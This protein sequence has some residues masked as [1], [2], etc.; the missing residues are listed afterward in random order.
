MLWQTAAAM[1]STE[2]TSVLPSTMAPRAS[3]SK[4]PVIVAGIVALAAV[5]AT[6]AMYLRQNETAASLQESRARVSEIEGQLKRARTELAAVQQDLAA[7]SAELQ[8]LQEAPL[9]VDVTFRVGRPGTGFIAQF[10]NRSAEPLLVIV[11]V[12]RPST[13][14]QKTLD[15]EVP[16]RGLGELG[17]GNG[18]GFAS[19][20]VLAVKGGEYRPLTLRTP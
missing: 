5:A 2:D 15:V 7:R 12:T 3:A 8:K 1:P 18:W 4:T 13:G 16:A 14:E 17:I 9:P 11:D 10:D 19:G 6:V 20:D